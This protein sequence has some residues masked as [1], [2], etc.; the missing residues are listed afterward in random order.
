MASIKKAAEQ[1][2]EQLNETSDGSQK[3]LGKIRSVEFVGN[4]SVFQLGKL[5][6]VSDGMVDIQEFPKEV[7]L[8]HPNFPGTV[9]RVPKTSILAIQ[10]GSLDA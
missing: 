3:L 8:T 5:S 1:S 4:V 6:K 7:W 10:M 9:I 2:V